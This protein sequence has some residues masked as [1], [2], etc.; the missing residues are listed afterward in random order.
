MPHVY[1]LLT[2]TGTLFSRTIRCWTRR[3]LNHASI[4][5]D[6]DLGEV[7]SFGRL[8][9]HHP[10]RAGFVR[11]RVWG[12]LIRDPERHT[13]CAIY[14]CRLG[15]TACSRL[16]AELERFR[17]EAPRYRYNLAGLLALAAGIEWRRPYRY[18][19]SQFV[20]HLFVAAGAPLVRKPP[21]LTTPCD[22]EASP[23]LELVY[24]G[25]LRAYCLE[26]GMPPGDT[27]VTTAPSPIA[28]MLRSAP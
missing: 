3:P 23:R 16:L 17:L 22:L 11:E 1:I 9:P 4:A 25:D 15:R 13:P 24:R 5:L 20:A 21:A 26:R 10:F 12:S 27:A 8:R 7:Y 18:F 2:D 19:C 28:R 6:P 14:R